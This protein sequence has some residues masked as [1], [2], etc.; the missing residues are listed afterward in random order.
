[1]II[2]KMKKIL[3]HILIAAYILVYTA[4]VGLCASTVPQINAGVAKPVLRTNS[5]PTMLKLEGDISFSKANPKISLSLRN[6]DVMQVLRMFADK[7]GLNIV[8]HSSVSG[9]VTLDLVNVP[10]NEAFK[11]VMQ[12]TN[13]TYYIDNN[14][15]VVASA[16]AAQNMNLA[17]QDLMVLPVKYVDAAMLAEFLNKNI[18]SMNKPG[19]SNA[20]IAV[21]N[22]ATN[23]LLIFGTKNDYLMAKK[24]VAQFDIKP[25]EETFVVNHS[26][27][28]EMSTLLCNLLFKENVVTSTAPASSGSSGTANTSSS[29]SSSSNST[30]SDNSSTGQNNG[31]NNSTSPT[32]INQTSAPA[33]LPGTPTGGASSISIGNS[34]DP[35]SSLTLGTGVIACQY[36]SAVTAGS[37][38]SLNTPSLSITYFPQRGTI[39]V[40]GGSAQQMEMIK[41]FILKNDKKQPQAILEVSIIELNEDGSR[42]FNNTWQ[43]WSGFFSGSFSGGTLANNPVYP[44]LLQGDSYNIT[45]VKSTTDPS[46]TLYTIGRYAGMP[47]VAWTVNYII[48][49]T[50]G[51]VLANPKIMVTNGEKSTIDLSSD[52]V[53][54][55]TSQIIT[56]SGSLTPSVQRTYNIGSD[57]GIKVDLLPFIS[58]DGYVTLNITP[59]YSTIKE[60]VTTPNAS[61]PTIEDLQATLLQRRNLDLKNIRIRDGE[62]LVIGGMIKETEQ[63]VIKKLPVLGD[64][65]GL[66]MLFRNTSTTKNK[67]ELVIMITPKIVKDSEDIVN[68]T[69]VTL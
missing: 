55:V 56:S 34:S 62:T 20:Q 63:K 1:M 69:S 46:K 38:A 50:K 2:Q 61:D 47:T 29:S 25:L 6:S 28:K 8:F 9:T 57:E 64:L 19:L 58:P 42:Q 44:F 14:T 37:L 31:S 23:D 11:L 60:R 10:L 35:S 59:S 43:V 5:S 49:N 22:P 15:M 32:D 17:K 39:Q 40:L 21:T 68:D 18:F 41:N 4:P 30:S 66:G 65:P 33:S 27:P 12:I 48:E 7:A 26:T 53:K 52:Y 16:D 3:S 13:L 45:D 67:E 54:T 36:N 51:R 24:V